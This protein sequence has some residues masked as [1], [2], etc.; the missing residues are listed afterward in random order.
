VIWL[1]QRELRAKLALQPRDPS[2]D[3]AASSGGGDSIRGSC[4]CEWKPMKWQEQANS[5]VARFED[6]MCGISGE[7]KEGT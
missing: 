7:K 3:S 2:I 4:W 1:A 6:K 5:L